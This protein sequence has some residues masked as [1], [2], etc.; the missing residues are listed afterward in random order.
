MLNYNGEPFTNCITKIDG[1][2][3]DDAKELVLHYDVQFD[4][5]YF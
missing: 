1:T 3:K 4:R 2:T 5:I